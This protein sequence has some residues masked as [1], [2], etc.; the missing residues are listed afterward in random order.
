MYTTIIVPVDLNH[1]DRVTAM[2]DAAR[3]VGG[4]DARIV[5]VNAV[6]DIPA[7]FMPELPSGVLEETMNRSREAMNKL[8][9]ESGLNAEAEVRNGDPANTI[10]D[11]SKEIG[12]DLII[13]ASH[14]PGWQDYLIG[15]TA[16]RV[17]RHAVC[18]VLVVR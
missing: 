8:A 18:S 5:L 12:A 16:A 14:K 2:L 7:H 6:E 9:E 15:S 13:I 1:E 10:L 17:V 3:E 4:N 11:L